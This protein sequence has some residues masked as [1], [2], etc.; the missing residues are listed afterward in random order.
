MTVTFS[1]PQRPATYAGYGLGVD[2]VASPTEL[3]AYRSPP[4]S[5]PLSEVVATRA[6]SDADDIVE[7]LGSAG[8][9]GRRCQSAGRT[10]HA[11]GLR[12]FATGPISHG[13]QSALK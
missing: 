6:Y 7:W 5:P 13:V 2:D 3:I 1:K 8:F 11:E 12:R 9:P 10:S 4:G